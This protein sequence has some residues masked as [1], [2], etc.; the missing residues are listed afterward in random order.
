MP[1]VAIE[2]VRLTSSS[3]LSQRLLWQYLEY[4]RHLKAGSSGHDLRALGLSPGRR[5]GAILRRL[6]DAWI[7]G[8]IADAQHERRMLERLARQAKRDRA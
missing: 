1:I 5:Y 3:R 6:R 8:E 7:D 4:W 2:A